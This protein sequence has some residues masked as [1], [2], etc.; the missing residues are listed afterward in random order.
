MQAANPA[1]TDVSAVELY[2]ANSG[3]RPPSASGPGLAVG[4][5]DSPRHVLVS[6][7]SA[8]EQLT[9]Q[10]TMQRIIQRYIFDIQREAEVTEG[11][12]NL[13]RS[14]PL[15]TPLSHPPLPP[16]TYNFDGI[17]VMSMF[18]NVIMLSL[19]YVHVCVTRTGWKTR[20][21][22]TTVILSI[23]KSNQINQ[24]PTPLSFDFFCVC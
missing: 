22:P 7:D 1:D 14:V 24:T 23:K 20:P 10:K 11:R 9:Y 21:R 5:V 3:V 12:W 16:P 6:V 4:G 2:E 8:Q 19:L 18:C 15:S 13:R 17:S